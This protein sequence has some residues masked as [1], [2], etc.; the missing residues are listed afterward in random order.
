MNLNVCYQLFVDVP[1]TVEK[2][3]DT[4]SIAFSC[5]G[6]TYN[7]SLSI[8]R[9]FYGRFTIFSFQFKELDIR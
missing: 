6:S 4:H 9:F 1:G 8:G 2:F 5:A 7:Y 3:L